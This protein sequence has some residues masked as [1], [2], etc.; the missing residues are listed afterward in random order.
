MRN[1][2]IAVLALLLSL[3]GGLASSD[4]EARS[5]AQAAEMAAFF[6]DDLAPYGRWIE[7]PAY[8]VVW[9]PESGHPDWHPYWDG[10][11]V[12]TADYGWYWHSHE[13]YG[14][15][16][17]H[18]GRWVLTSD[19]GWVWV[20]DTVWGPAWVEWR[21]GGGYAG[22]APMPPPERQEKKGGAVEARAWV[23]VPAGNVTKGDMQRAASTQTTD[24][25]AATS[26]A[27][28]A[29]LAAT[30]RIRPEPVTSATSAA[31]QAS[32]QANGKVAIYRPPQLSG[33]NPSGALNFDVP[34]DTSTDLD[35]EAA[36]KARAKLDDAALPNKPLSGS[37][38]SA[39]GG[40]FGGEGTMR[41]P[42]ASSGGGGGIG[43]GIPGAGGVR[44]GR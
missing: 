44:L 9:V 7:H 29:D 16:T 41:A 25:L 26:A 11:W 22:W 43:V 32:A 8:G 2:L 13:P 34:L 17:Y 20:P 24:L 23:F 40:T 18:Y 15:A 4:V 28:G 38:D 21:Y 37:V 10:R 3:C 19:Y 27:A 5:R 39:I 33:L 35:P 36:A 1:R 12:W 31:E 42:S 14:W 6:H 30:L